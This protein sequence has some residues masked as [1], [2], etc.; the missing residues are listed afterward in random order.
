MVIWSRPAPWVIVL[1]RTF[2][3]RKLHVSPA[4]HF[5][6]SIEGVIGFSATERD[7]SHDMET[8]HRIIS[9]A[10]LFTGLF[11]LLSDLDSCGN[12]VFVRWFRVLIAQL[13]IERGH[14]QAGM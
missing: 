12:S 8:M 7:V 6:A 3:V 9:A 5:G 1:S 2:S 14:V 10:N 13:F 4:F 11:S